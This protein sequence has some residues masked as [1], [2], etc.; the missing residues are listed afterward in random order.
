MTKYDEDYLNGLIKKAKKSWEGVDVDSYMNNL[1]DDSFDKEV[2]E[3]LSKEVTS[4]IIEQIKSNMNTV[5]IKCRD[6]M[7]GDLVTNEHGLPAQIISVGNACAYTIFGGDG[8][9]EDDEGDPWVFDDYVYRPVPIP[10]TPE[11]L[12]KNEWK[13]TE[14]WHEYKDGN[15]IIQYS[16]SN[17]W[18]IINGVE[19]EH[20][21]CEYVHQLQHLF[22]LCGLNELAD[23]FKV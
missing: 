2:A 17:I 9:D 1:R 8:D 16:L 3:K 15:T 7:I 11:I 6:L 23:N 20:F 10:L 18:G 19:I 22:R 14:Y 4:Y 21:K 5:I 12:E 13:E